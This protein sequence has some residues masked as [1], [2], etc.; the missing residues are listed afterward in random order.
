VSQEP[1]LVIEPLGS[2]HD[3]QGFQCGNESL[4]TYLK[5][6][7]SQD[8]KRRIC[9]VYVAI[10]PAKPASIL[11]FYT[12][13]TSAIELSSLPESQ[14][15]KLPKHPLPAALLGRLA[16]SQSQQGTGLGRLLLAN[17]IRRTLA[18]SDQIGIYALLVDAIDEDARGFYQRYGFVSLQSQGQRLFLPLK[19][20]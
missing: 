6:Q 16:V 20:I 13:S 18:V 14:A 3:R 2:T 9:R 8:I 11:G 17:A 12:L 10:D 5:R 1:A 4:D 15:R 19:S 7:A